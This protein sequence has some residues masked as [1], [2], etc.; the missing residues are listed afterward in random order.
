MGEKR[1]TLQLQIDS[2]KATVE[3]LKA[4]ESQIDFMEE[5]FLQ[6][7]SHGNYYLRDIVGIGT[8]D[9]KKRV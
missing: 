1:S 3:E 7:Y 8:E 4:C 6:S 9:S 5:Y 2:Y